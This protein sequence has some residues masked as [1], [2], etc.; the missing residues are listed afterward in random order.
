MSFYENNMNQIKLGFPELYEILLTI[1]EPKVR[2]DFLQMENL[3]KFM[4]RGAR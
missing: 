1:D 3:E 4:V 2:Q